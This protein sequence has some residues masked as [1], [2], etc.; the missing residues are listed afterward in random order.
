MIKIYAIYDKS[1]K[2]Y[3]GHTK[4]SISARFASHIYRKRN[5]GQSSFNL[6]CGKTRSDFYIDILCECN[7]LEKFDLEKFWIN[8]LSAVNSYK[9]ASGPTSKEV[10][11]KCGKKASSYWKKQW[12]ENYEKTRKAVNKHKTRDFQQIANKAA[13]KK[14]YEL[15]PL[16]EV[17]CSKSNKAI[18]EFKTYEELCNVLNLKS[19]KT[20]YYYINGLIGNSNYKKYYFREVCHYSK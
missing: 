1:N 2:C 17:V 14:K 8:E 12:K 4:Q 3:V 9:K 6:L 19:K 10:S 15:K 16:K 20:A 11:K 18:G 13:N 7:D 5:N